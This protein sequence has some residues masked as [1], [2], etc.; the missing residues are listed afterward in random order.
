MA[1]VDQGTELRTALETFET[2]LETPLVSGEHA[3]WSERVR[4]TW[5]QLKP[6]VHRQLEEVHPQLFDEIFET[7]AELARRIEQLRDED[8]ALR[9]EMQRLDERIE[10]LAL[11]TPFA[12]RDELRTTDERDDLVEDGIAFV[13]RTRKQEVAAQTWF[14]EAFNRERGPGD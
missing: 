12:E 13:V 3:T 10:T 5:S 14:V 4:E 6:L 2:A 11:R 9:R 8:Q 1:T 7:D